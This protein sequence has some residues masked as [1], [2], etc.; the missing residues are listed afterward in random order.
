MRFLIQK[1]KK[2]CKRDKNVTPFLRAFYVGP[3]D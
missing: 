3:I 2:V 1:N